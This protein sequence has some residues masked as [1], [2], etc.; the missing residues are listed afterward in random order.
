MTSGP[1]IPKI[2]SLKVM[3][4]ELANPQQID[5]VRAA[6][7]VG[8]LRHVEIDRQLADVPGGQRRLVGNNAE[9]MIADAML[10]LVNEKE[11]PEG[12]SQG[13][14]DWMRRRAVEIL[15]CLGGP[16]QNNNVLGGP[17]RVA[18]GQQGPRVAPLLGG[19]SLGAA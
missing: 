5:G 2:E 4:D 10:K 17:G 8:I 18:D 1:P 13:G 19:R 3:L 11:A 9:I 15:G 6:A 16:G 14:H 7:L 12:R